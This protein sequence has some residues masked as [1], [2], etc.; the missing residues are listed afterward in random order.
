MEEKG[1]RA[2]ALKNDEAAVEW[3]LQLGA[4]A[5][6][7]NREGKRAIRPALPEAA[8]FHIHHGVLQH[9]CV[10]DGG[11]HEFQRRRAAR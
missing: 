2:A 4:D 8:K 10:P 5:D 11:Q 1:A 7:V 3:R 9:R 6:A